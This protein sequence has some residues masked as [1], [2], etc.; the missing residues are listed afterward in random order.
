MFFQLRLNAELELDVCYYNEKLSVWEPLIEPSMVQEGEYKPWQLR[1]Q[2]K[3]CRGRGAGGRRVGRARCLLLQR[4]AECLGP[5]MVQEGEYLPWQLRAQVKC[6][7]G[8]GAGGRR[9][10]R[11]RCLLL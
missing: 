3:C 6:C 5:S 1:A 10:G 11:A 9:V 7:R 4:E 2:V 8:R